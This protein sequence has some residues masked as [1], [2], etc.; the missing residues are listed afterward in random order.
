MIEKKK[1]ERE[2]ELELIRYRANHKQFE[3]MGKEK[4]YTAFWK[5]ISLG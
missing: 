5:G 1:S 3:K 4:G 2:A